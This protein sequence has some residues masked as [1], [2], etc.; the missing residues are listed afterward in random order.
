M[1]GNRANRNKRCQWLGLLVTSVIGVSAAQ[2][3]EPK[4]K[5][6]SIW[7][8]DTLTGDW[9]GA[10]TALKEKSGIDITLNYIGETFSVLSGGLNRGSTYEGRIEFSVDTDL[11][12]LIGWNGATT[13]V[14][15]YQIHNGGR[16]AL[17]NVGSISDP[18]NIDAL[19]TTR[20]F[21]A[22]YQQNFYDDK[23][24]VRLGQLAADD[25]FIIS[26]TAGGLIN[27]T[28]GW[29][30]LFAA[31]MLSGGPAYPVATPGVRVA[32]KPT[33]ELTVL[34]AVFNGNPAGA[35]CDGDPQACNRYGLDFKM[36]GGALAMSELQYAIN[37]DK[38][39]AGLPGVYK[40]GAWYANTDFPDAYSGVLNKSG[41]WGVYGVAD[42]MVWRGRESSVNL[43]MR[44]GFSPSDRNLVSYYIDG[45][46]G[47][48]GLVPGRADDV[49]TFGAAYIKVSSDV[50]DFDRDNGD[51]VRSAETVLEL[52]YQAQLAPWWVLQPDLQY[53]IK[54]NGG[55]N[56]DNPKLSYDHA[57]LVG[58]RSTIKF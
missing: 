13:H 22:W 30:A 7:E 36:T 3:A 27:G 34:A 37:Q 8:Q 47:I 5:P 43:F 17:D 28:F 11:A 23:I 50:A 39:A 9:G 25:E 55:Q 15:V 45:G 41:D 33:D 16:D 57:F 42:Q 32:V 29:A 35:G 38:K 26:P 10:R 4:D 18:S 31:D 12:K 46:F 53:I 1:R 51:A 49:L 14:T 54:P 40:L 20:L 6:K 44:G 21:T 19:A 58:L 56:P 52:S 24:S 48:K 2:A